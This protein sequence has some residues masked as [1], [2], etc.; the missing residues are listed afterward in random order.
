[1]A[2]ALRLTPRTL[3]RRLAAE[4]QPF[5]S[6]VDG[7]RRAQAE[8]WLRVG[9]S[10]AETS[11]LVGYSEP[12]AFHRAFKRW[13]GTTPEAWRLEAAVPLTS[14]STTRARG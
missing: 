4:G 5:A 14:G 12:R 1:V 11:F 3:Q 6:V 8:R 7:I 13:I 9:T 2:G 10:I